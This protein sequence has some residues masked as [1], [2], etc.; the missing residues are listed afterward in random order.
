MTH[1]PPVP[2]N[3]T[4]AEPSQEPLDAAPGAPLA[5][6]AAV[7]FESGAVGRGGV[8]ATLI[9]SPFPPY[10]AMSSKNGDFIQLP[11]PSGL[12]KLQSPSESESVSNLLP[13]M[14]SSKIAELTWYRLISSKLRCDRF[15]INV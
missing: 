7:V 3:I 10:P 13:L 2:L 4:I 8:L 14:P 5:P 15:L 9:L 12:S 6:L 11:S 1:P